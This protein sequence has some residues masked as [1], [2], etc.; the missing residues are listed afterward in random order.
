MVETA[1]VSQKTKKETALIT[2][3]KI[4]HLAKTKSQKLTIGIKELD[5]V[6][7]DGLVP[8]QV[9][10]FAGE[11]GIG[12]STL[13]TQLSL[14]LTKKKKNY[15]Y[16]ICGEESPQQVGLR[17]LR[18]TKKT[19]L[20]DHF[21]LLPETD[22]DS[23]VAFLNNLSPPPTLVVVDSIQ[24]LTTT[25]LS[26]VAGSIGQVRESAQ[27]L[28]NWAKKNQVPVLIVGHIT[29]QGAIAGP[30]VLEH[31][32]DTVVYFEGERLSD[33]RV[34]RAMKNRFG[35]TD[36]VGVFKMSETG[37]IPV[38][39]DLLVKI[40]EKPKTAA[41]LTIVAEGTRLMITE[42]QALVSQSYTPLPKRVIT[43]LERNRS[44]MLIAVV[45]KQLRLPLFR[46]DIF[47]NV[48]GGLKVN[49][50]AADLAICAAIFSS[51][52]NKPLPAKSCFVGEVSLLGEVSP[53]SQMEKRKKQASGLGIKTIFTQHNLPSIQ[54]LSRII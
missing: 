53:A 2:P 18:L 31:A 20:N 16:Y 23:L 24:S 50:P 36:E 51:Y 26:G 10:L 54:H 7:G 35:P 37:L 25:D 30:K 46:Y 4:G 42:I 3:V 39:E 12:K 43:G 33:L 19:V 48:A 38:N 15:I 47:I 6:L 28:I 41:A 34:L 27:R 13:L 49:E 5:R 1:I 52:K 29:K 32:V 14:A 40:M 22:V 11:P 9:V 8:G 21:L 44:E 45:Q 17:V